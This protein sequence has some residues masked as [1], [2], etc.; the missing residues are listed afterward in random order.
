MLK[1]FLAYYRPYKVHFAFVVIGSCVA[2]LLDLVFPVLVRHIL[3]VELP[4]KN[5]DG[6]LYWISLLFGM[7]CFNFGLLFCIN[8]FGH[9]MSASIENDMRRDMFTHL[10]K[11]P[12]VFTTM[13]K[14]GSCFP[15]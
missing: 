8:Y 12:S 1:Y 2:A 5:I 10:Q 4:Q 7:Y 9:I 13:L 6:I 11:C 3:N 14:L 15:V